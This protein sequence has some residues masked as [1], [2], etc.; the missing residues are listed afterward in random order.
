MKC[1]FPDRYCPLMKT[2]KGGTSPKLMSSLA[3]GLVLAVIG[4]N[5]SEPAW[6]QYSI[7]G[8]AFVVLAT[9]AYLMI[10]EQRRSKAPAEPGDPE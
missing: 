8:I 10:R 6:L 5:V 3:L 2:T 1:D 4:T 9:T 7:Q